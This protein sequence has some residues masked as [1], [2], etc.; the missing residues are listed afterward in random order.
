MNFLNDKSKNPNPNDYNPSSLRMYNSKPTNKHLHVQIPME[1]EVPFLQKEG[2]GRD[3]EDR[4]GDIGAHFRPFFLPA[5]I[6]AELN[7]VKRV[8]C[9]FDG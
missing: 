8:T 9:E 6:Q 5:I 7:E 2:E 1:A 4:P 3:L